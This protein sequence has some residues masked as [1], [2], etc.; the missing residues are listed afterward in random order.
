MYDRSQL[1]SLS[2]SHTVSYRVTHYSLS[3]VSLFHFPIQRVSSSCGETQVPFFFFFS[4]ERKI[5]FL[6]V[7]SFSLWRRYLSLDTFITSPLCPPLMHHLWRL[8]KCCMSIKVNWPSGQLKSPF[9]CHFTSTRPFDGPLSP[10]T[11]LNSLL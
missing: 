8:E 5:T 1:I 10:L 2:L 11:F 4:R 6:R 7:Y 3:V 9:R